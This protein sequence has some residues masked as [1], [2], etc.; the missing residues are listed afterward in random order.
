MS[1]VAALPIQSILTSSIIPLDTLADLLAPSTIVASFDLG[2]SIVH[3][4]VHPDYGN[5][6]LVSTSGDKN[7]VLRA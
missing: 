1:A 4:V 3:Q 2:A 6:T 5:L 7:A